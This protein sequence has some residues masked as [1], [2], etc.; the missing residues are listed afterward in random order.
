I[1]F[2]QVGGSVL[3]FITAVLVATH[4][5]TIWQLVIIGLFQGTL[6]AFSWPAR[7]ALMAEVVRK[8]DVMSAIAMANA[9]QNMTRLIG[10]ARAGV[11]IGA[12]DM[13]FASGRSPRCTRCRP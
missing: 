9:A 8:H 5:I 3:M 1:L 2:S 12:W 11:L 10:P 13:E 4:V 6:F 7:F